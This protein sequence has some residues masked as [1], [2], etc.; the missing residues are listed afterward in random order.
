MDRLAWFKRIERKFV[1][2]WY[3]C[4]AAFRDKIIV[5]RHFLILAWCCVSILATSGCMT[6]NALHLPL[7]GTWL[8]NVV[9]TEWGEMQFKCV[10]YTDSDGIIHFMNTSKPHASETR[11]WI[12]DDG[13]I[14][15]PLEASRDFYFHPDRN[16]LHLTLS[17]YSDDQ[18]RIFEYTW[19][20]TR[21]G[22]PE[23]LRDLVVGGLERRPSYEDL[24]GKSG[25]K[26]FT[27]SG[28]HRENVGSQNSR[29]E[30]DDESS[31]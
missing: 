11:F 15:A 3:F 7:S 13:V 12:Q 26:T 14:V 17:G 1:M 5:A 29:L 10:F 16:R 31:D 20:F 25:G 9:D 6:S 4:F 2:G 23:N 24:F 22:P 30:A 19:V 28:S 18:S 8:S 27:P 21:T